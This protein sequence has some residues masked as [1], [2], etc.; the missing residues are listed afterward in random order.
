MKYAVIKDELVVN[1]II[2][3]GEAPYNP[4][5]GCQLIKVAADERV[6]PG[7]AYI[8]NEFIEPKQDN[9]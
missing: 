4:G 9:L 6:G 3:D 7:F 1:V 2:W 5:E 8:N